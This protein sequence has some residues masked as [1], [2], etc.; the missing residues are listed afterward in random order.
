MSAV[1]SDP[2]QERW[3]NSRP[4]ADPPDGHWLRETPQLDISHPRLHFT[5]QKLTQSRQTHAARAVAVH[6]FVRRLP[7]AASG[8]GS[9]RR[10]S[11]VLRQGRGD[12]HTKGVLFVA[13]CRAAGLPARLQFVDVVPR[14]LHG[15]LDEGPASMPHAVGQVLVEDRWWSTDGYVVDPALFASARQK[16]RDT[17]EGTGWGIVAEAQAQWDGRTDCLQQFRQ[18]DV[19][20]VFTP[21]HDTA[22]FYGA[23]ARQMGWAGWLRYAVGAHLV[24]RRV[25]Q[26]RR[27]S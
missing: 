23:A 27:R 16:L 10:A 9:T 21:C 11:E 18:A 5:A 13:L 2:V 26:A 15:I 8:D 1:L 12:C 4:A 14:F 22:H 3:L 24:N 25:R 17:G 7:F 20:E 19:L 6:D